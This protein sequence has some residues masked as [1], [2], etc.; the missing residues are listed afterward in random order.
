[1]IDQN[2]P[3]RFCSGVPERHQR[4]CVA[5]S[6]NAACAVPFVRPLMRWASSRT[7]RHHRVRKSGDWERSI[8]PSPSPS[9]S[10]SLSGRGGTAAAAA[11]AAGAVE[12]AAVPAAEPEPSQSPEPAPP[13]T[14]E[15]T[16]RE[17]LLERSP[18]T[19]WQ[20]PASC[21][22]PPPPISPSNSRSLSSSPPLSASTSSE[23][24]RVVV[25]GDRNAAPQQWAAGEADGTAGTWGNSNGEPGSKQHWS[26]APP[27]ADTSAAAL[28]VP[29]AEESHRRGLAGA[30]I[31]TS[32]A[33]FCNSATGA[34]VASAEKLRA[35]FFPVT[36]PLVLSPRLPPQAV[37]AR[38]GGVTAASVYGLVVNEGFDITF[39]SLC[40][41]TRPFAANA[42]LSSSL[43]RRPLLLTPPVPFFLPFPS[44][45]GPTP[46]PAQP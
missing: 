14:D 1:M 12:P 38:G 31:P 27:S 45:M 13:S 33:F 16:G 42:S 34:I 22:A 2:S 40:R 10:S 4:A 11:A 37:R 44:A 26:P 17:E 9:S 30:A 5:L 24:T 35:L 41:G 20:K 32:P 19:P 15:G 3:T 39:A 46:P 8:R 43:G 21:E 25:G 29:N 18:V 6:A 7:T 23:I 28:V 36:A